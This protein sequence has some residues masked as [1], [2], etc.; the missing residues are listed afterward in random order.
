[1]II[2]SNVLVASGNYLSQFLHFLLAFFSILYVLS[3]CIFITLLTHLANLIFISFIL[4]YHCGLLLI[5]CGNICMFYFSPL[6]PILKYNTQQWVILPILNYLDFDRSLYLTTS[7]TFFLIK[8]QS[9]RIFISLSKQFN[10][11]PPL[12]PS[13][14]YIVVVVRMLFCPLSF[15]WCRK[16]LKVSE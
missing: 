2:F 1:M 10:S 16:S 5:C 3:L 15:L 13:F 14:F 8:L 6:P 12:P 4:C 11:P 9:L 7:V